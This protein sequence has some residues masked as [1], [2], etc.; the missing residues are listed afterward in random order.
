MFFT[1][2]TT[3]QLQLQGPTTLDENGDVTVLGK[4]KRRF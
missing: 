4:V 3:Q 1:A 2:K